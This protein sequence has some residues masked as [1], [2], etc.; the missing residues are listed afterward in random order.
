[1]SISQKPEVCTVKLNCFFFALFY[2]FVFDLQG[3]EARLQLLEPQDE[4]SV[5]RRLHGDLTHLKGEK[6]TANDQERETQTY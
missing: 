2:L 4:L 1:M 3:S 5:H 6:Q